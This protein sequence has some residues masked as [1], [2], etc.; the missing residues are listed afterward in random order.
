[1]ATI[2]VG[3]LPGVLVG[4]ALIGRVSSTVLRPTLG[5]VLLG[6]ALGVM[7]KAGV[8]VPPG[9]LVG[10]PLAVGGCAWLLTRGRR[11]APTNDVEV[12]PA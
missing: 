3:S 7:K 4:T 8:D 9:A 5:C 6:S 12:V 2:L 1:M 11:V 10:L